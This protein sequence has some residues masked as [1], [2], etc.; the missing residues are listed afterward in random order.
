MVTTIC[1]DELEQVHLQYAP[2]FF[3]VFSIFERITLVMKCIDITNFLILTL[4]II[5]Q[6]CYDRTQR[7]D[8]RGEVQ[9]LTG[10]IARD[11]LFLAADSV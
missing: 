9:F 4:A 5:G 7:N 2:A 1:Q 8:F 11:R 6:A 10:G 3:M